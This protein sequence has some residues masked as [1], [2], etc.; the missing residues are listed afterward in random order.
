M[1][2]KNWLGLIIVVVIIPVLISACVHD[3]NGTN[4]GNDPKEYRVKSITTIVE[5]SGGRVDWC[6]ANNYIAYDSLYDIWVM[7]PDGSDLR[8]LTCNEFPGRYVGN[9]AWSPDGQ[10]ILL[11]VEKEDHGSLSGKIPENALEPGWGVH[12][13]L[14]IVKIDLNEPQPLIEKWCLVKV[15]VGKGVVHPHFSKDGTK[16]LWSE[17]ITFDDND[18]YTW[19]EAKNSY[20]HLQDWRLKIAD[21]TVND[22][23]PTLANITTL[24]RLPNTKILHEA[25]G[26][27]TDGTRVLFASNDKRDA[28]NWPAFDIYTY[29]LKTGDL[30]KLTNTIDAWE[31]HAHYSPD[32]K[33]IIWS[34]NRGFDIG[35]YQREFWLMDEDGE[36]KKQLTHFHTP[37]YSEYAGSYYAIM[38]A[39]NAWNMDGTSVAAFAKEMNGLTIEIRNKIYRLD[40]EIK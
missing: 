25:H 23:V 19:E 14:W 35:S 30:K 10:F 39:D 4:N 13:E 28:S 26:F 7:E 22:E 37:G 33:K 8:S 40:F 17:I 21:F 29:N 9:P 1:K 36:N 5:N 6:V 11:Q 16:I 27:S 18:P 31:E 34:S 24:P 3:E 38:C 32:G 2:S 15:P 12:N 20:E